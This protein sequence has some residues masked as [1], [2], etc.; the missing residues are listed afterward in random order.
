MKGWEE[1][2]REGQK[3]FI[4]KKENIWIKCMH[5]IM[6]EENVR[7][8]WL[9]WTSSQELHIREIAVKMKNYWRNKSKGRKG[10]GEVMK[11]FSHV[12]VLA[13][14]PNFTKTL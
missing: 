5:Y 10:E 7:L 8:K 11:S 6:N 4:T 1:E 9:S 14:S 3:D 13:S 2:R 12:I